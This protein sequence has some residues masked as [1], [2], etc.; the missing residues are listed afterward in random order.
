MT[1]VTLSDEQT[2]VIGEATSPIVLVDPQGCEVATATHINILPA[3]AS[4]EEV[5]AEIYR[6]MATDDGQRFSHAEVMA[7]LRSLA[8]QCCDL[9]DVHAQGVGRIGDAVA[10][11]SGSRRCDESQ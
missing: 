1:V 11:R 5:V 10:K 6:R 7:H 8:P 9:V 4:E 2:R 3:D